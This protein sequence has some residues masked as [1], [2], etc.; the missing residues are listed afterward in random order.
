[1]LVDND[2]FPVTCFRFRVYFDRV[3]GCGGNTQKLTKAISGVLLADVERLAIR[4][5]QAVDGADRRVTARVGYLTAGG[6]QGSIRVRVGRH[7]CE[8]TSGIP[9]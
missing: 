4:L 7:F 3:N 1:M 9:S 6:D 8:E 5:V 2:P